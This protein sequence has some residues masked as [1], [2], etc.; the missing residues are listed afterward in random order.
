MALEPVVRRPLAILLENAGLA[1]RL[2][3]VEGALEDD[4]AES[5]HQRAVRIA[6]A[7][8]ERVVLAVAGHPFLGDDRCRE[9]QP[10][11][12]RKRGEIMQLYAAMC[13]RAMQKQRDADVG[14]CPAI[15]MNRT[16]LPPVCCPASKIRHSIRAPMCVQLLLRI[17]IYRIAPSAA[18][19][20]VL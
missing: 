19:R 15:T 5:F 7:V 12:H 10:E 6:L 3:I 1:H 8:G 4:V 20:T 11:P 14:E 16:R 9:P 18:N 13:L 17:A 2:P